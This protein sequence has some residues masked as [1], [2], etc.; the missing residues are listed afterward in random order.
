MKKIGKE[1]QE[2]TKIPEIKKQRN[3]KSQHKLKQLS[4]LILLILHSLPFC[5]ALLKDPKNA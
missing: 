2:K 4:K 1:E 3:L 5:E